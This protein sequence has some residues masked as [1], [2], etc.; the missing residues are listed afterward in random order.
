[1]VYKE[2][3][4]GVYQVIYQGPD[5]SRGISRGLANGLSKCL[6]RGLSNDLS[7]GLSSDLLRAGS[8]KGSIK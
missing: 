7:R 6:S 2:V 4:Q 5:L 1:M 3:C 8:I